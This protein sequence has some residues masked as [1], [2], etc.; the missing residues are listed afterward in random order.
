LLTWP[1][2]RGGN[3]GGRS[4]VF[5]QAVQLR[6]WRSCDGGRCWRPLGGGGRRMWASGGRA[7]VGRWRIPRGGA[8]GDA[9]WASSCRRTAGGRIIGIADDPAAG[10]AWALACLPRRSSRRTACIDDDGR[11]VGVVVR[12]PRRTGDGERLVSDGACR[13]DRTANAYQRQI[14]RREHR[15]DEHIAGSKRRRRR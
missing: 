9:A 10:D 2:R 12:L 5:R 8:G 11:C 4:D 14:R 15:L 3:S 7:G 1:C 13:A 6:A